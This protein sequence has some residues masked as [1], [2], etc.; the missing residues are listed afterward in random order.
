MRRRTKNDSCTK[1][2]IERELDLLRGNCKNENMEIWGI[3][4]TLDVLGYWDYP[5]KDGYKIRKK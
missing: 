4:F 1:K 5:T 2:G 3:K